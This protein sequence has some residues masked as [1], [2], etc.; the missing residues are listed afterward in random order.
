VSSLD[1]TE[2][3]PTRRGGLTRLRWP[4]MVGAP[5]L[6]L[7]GVAVVVL[8]GG[9]TETTDDAYIQAAKA[10]ISAAIAGRVIEVDVAENQTVKA[11]QVLFKLDPVDIDAALH[12]DEATLAAARLQ[13]VGLHSTWDQQKL[14]LASAQQTRDYAVREAERQDALVKAGVSSQQQASDARHAA[15]LAIAQLAVAR[16]QTAAAL[17][18]LGGAQDRPDLYPSVLQ[19][20]AM[21]EAAQVDLAHTIIVAPSDGVVTRVDQLQKGA[22][23]NASQT[24]FFLLS[25]EPWIEA[26]FKENQLAKMRVGQRAKISIDA[27][28]GR[29]LNGYVASFSPGAGSSFSPLPA[30]NATGNWVK[31]VQRLPVRIAFDKAPPEVVSRAGLSAKITVDVSGLSRVVA[32][33]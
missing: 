16:Q 7:A 30:Q 1:A 8:T 11:G 19:A 17:A 26:N 13:V 21:L 12:R 14:L 20:K 29:E 32:A 18:N 4:L 10:P 5:L 3:T 23:V 15:D 25:G 31:V 9:K 33:R 24:V 6:L 28:G 27:L 2:P 22:Y